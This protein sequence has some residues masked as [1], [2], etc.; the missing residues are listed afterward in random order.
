MSFILNAMRPIIADWL[1]SE[2]TRE[3]LVEVM[4]KLAK[5]SNNAID[6][7]M[8]MGLARALNVDVSEEDE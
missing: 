2:A 1:M 5:E 7:M 8:V 6:D 4:Y 3:F